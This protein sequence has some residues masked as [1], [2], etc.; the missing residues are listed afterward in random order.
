MAAA[1]SSICRL[2]VATPT[3]S[4]WALTRPRCAA[5]GMNAFDGSLVSVSI[6]GVLTGRHDTS[7]SAEPKERSDPSSES[8]AYASVISALDVHA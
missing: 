2:T 4:C 3:D 7:G 5:H 1:A 8:K 6:S